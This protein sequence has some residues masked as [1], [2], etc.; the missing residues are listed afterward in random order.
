[1]VSVLLIVGS[2][3]GWKLRLA[4]VCFQALFSSFFSGLDLTQ[5]FQLVKV[6]V[7]LSVVQVTCGVPEG[8]ATG[9]GLVLPGSTLNL[10]LGEQSLIAFVSFLL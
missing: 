7:Y 4:P 9:E 6:L 5:R 1:M 8:E 3:N 2:W 10:L